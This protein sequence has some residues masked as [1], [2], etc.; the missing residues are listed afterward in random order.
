[1]SR[2]AAAL[3]A[4]VAV[5]ALAGCST[6]TSSTTGGTSTSATPTTSVSDGSAQ[7]LPQFPTAP[8]TPSLPQSSGLS[9]VQQFIGAVFTD[10][11]NEWSKVFAS[12]GVQYQ[13]ARLVLFSSAVN[14]ACGAESAKVGPFYCPADRTVYLDTSFFDEMQQRYGVG[15]D[16]AQAYV[17]AHE[18]GHHVQ[19]LTGV[20][21]QVA[22]LRQ[23]F[24]ADS[25]NLSVL[26]ELQADC[27]A[28]VWA[29]ST[30]RRGLL[31]PGDLQEA[32]TAAA[33]VGDD[34]LQKS[35]TGSVQPEAWTHG[36]SAQRQQWLAV[37]YDS[38]KPA[39]CNTF[40]S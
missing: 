25:N 32:L 10:A 14:T 40:A 6:G 20:A 34:F 31:E 13:P 4:F 11:Q 21:A 38:G 33:A 17:V 30:Y 27:Y 12:A 5:L 1:M 8:S 35:A 24:P 9:Q 28:G 29:Y 23:R 22:A 7:K 19:N 37:G 26:T 36:S 18:L 15:G 39:S 2:T 16:F 3:A